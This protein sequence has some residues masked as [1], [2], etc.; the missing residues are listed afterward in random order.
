MSYVA[1]QILFWIIIAVIFGFA[2]GWMTNSRRGS[3][4]RRKKRRF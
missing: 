3:R 1:A 2:L 4:K